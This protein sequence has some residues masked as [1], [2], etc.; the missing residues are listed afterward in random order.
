[1]GPIS[2]FCVNIRWQLA[3]QPLN[4]LVCPVS[5]IFRIATSAAPKLLGR[6]RPVK[7]WCLREVLTE[8][9]AR[10][11]HYCCESIVDFQLFPYIMVTLSNDLYSHILSSLTVNDCTSCHKCISHLYTVQ[12]NILY[13]SRKKGNLK[14]LK[15]AVPHGY[16]FFAQNPC[17]LCL[18]TKGTPDLYLLKLKF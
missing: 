6:L 14:V 7:R 1:M 11:K 16:R 8:I 15:R 18:C 4:W 17:L 3:T 12:S 13:W 5:C 2:L 9:K 10:G